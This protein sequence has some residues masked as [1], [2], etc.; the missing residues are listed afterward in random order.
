MS[1]CT[2]VVSDIDVVKGEIV[3][4]D[5]GLSGH[6]AD[7]ND[8][9]K[10][11]DAL[12]SELSAQKKTFEHD[13][14]NVQGNLDEQTDRALRNNITLI[15]I[16]QAPGEKSW[17]DITKAVSS[18]LAKETNKSSDHFYSSIERAHRMQKRSYDSTTTPAII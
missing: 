9:K 17:D 6:E 5:A 1:W 2:G 4:L 15:G 11:N 7:I 12:L 16:P 8:L 18:W 10:A 14:A 13:I 3:Q